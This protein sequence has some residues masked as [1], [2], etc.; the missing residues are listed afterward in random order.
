VLTEVKGNVS[1]GNW[2]LFE[3]SITRLVMK[4][5]CVRQSNDNTPTFVRMAISEEAANCFDLS[6]GAMMTKNSVG[7]SPKKLNIVTSKS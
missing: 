6:R 5:L 7:F 1:F 2:Q 3:V 4:Y